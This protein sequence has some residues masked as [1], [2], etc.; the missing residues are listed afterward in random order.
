[1]VV[2]NKLRNYGR[3]IVYHSFFLCV[4]VCVVGGGGLRLLLVVVI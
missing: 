1:M 2:N 4:C 3:L